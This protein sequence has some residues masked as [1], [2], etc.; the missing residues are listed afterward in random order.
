MAFLGKAR[1]P[2]WVPKKAW[3]APELRINRVTIDDNISRDSLPQLAPGVRAILGYARCERADLV[4]VG[5]MWYLRALGPTPR[6]QLCDLIFVVGKG[7]PVISASTWKAVQGDPKK[8]ASTQVVFH[9]AASELKKV[10]FRY[11]GDFRM[12]NPEVMR[13]LHQ[14]TESPASKWKTQLDN[15]RPGT[16]MAAPPADTE[17]IE[18]TS[19]ASLGEWIMKSRVL[20]NWGC[21]GFGVKSC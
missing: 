10:I 15:S 1:V 6:Q 9:R 19:L 16:P 12:E 11:K 8:L 7:L 21:R 20:Q 3:K 2:K 18:I 13:A 5:A 17:L 4:V 14:C